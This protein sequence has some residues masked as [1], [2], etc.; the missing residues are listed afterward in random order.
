M[1][2]GKKDTPA[3]KQRAREKQEVKKKLSAAL[4]KNLMRRKINDD[5]VQK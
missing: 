4:R 1:K 2:E 3:K 5:V